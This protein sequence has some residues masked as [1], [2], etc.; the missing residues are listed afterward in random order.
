MSMN[1][2]IGQ[3]LYYYEKMRTATR[4]VFMFVRCTVINIMKDHENRD[5]TVVKFNRFY[6]PANRNGSEILT[7]PFNSDRV[8]LSPSIPTKECIR[9]IFG[10][11]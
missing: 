1:Y 8:F 3:T 10:E 11:E 2:Q 7:L 9:H 6:Y 4:T 5:R